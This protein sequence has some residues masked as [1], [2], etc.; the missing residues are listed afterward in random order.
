[1]KVLVINCGSSSVKYQLMDSETGS[2]LAKGM[3]ERIGFDDAVFTSVQRDP[4][5]LH[6]KAGAT[7]KDP[8]QVKTLPVKNHEIAMK[9]ILAGLVGERGVLGSLAEIGAVGHRFVNGG[10]EFIESVV[11]TD[12]VL[13]KLRRILDIAPLHNPANMLGIEACLTEM[14]DTPQ[15]IVFDTGF[16]ARVPAKAYMYALPYRYYEEYG[17]RRYGFHGTSHSYVSHRAAE[18]VG[19][20]V[21]DLRII[22]CHLGNGCSIDAVKDGWAVDTSMG[23]TPLEGLMMGTRTGDIDCAV[24]LSIMK[25]EGVTPEEMDAI[26]N[27]KSGLLGVTGIS[28]DMREIEGAARA[29]NE[30]AVLAIDMYCYRIRKYIAAYTGVL[31]GLDALVYTAGVGEHSSLVREKSCEGLEF[32]GIKIDPERNA[33]ATGGEAEIGICG[34]PVRILVVPTNE[35]LV[36]AREAERLGK[37]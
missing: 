10:R 18:L 32:L 6:A 17:I 13:G 24:P 26:L 25:R 37:R 31:S 2:V 5:L 20:P 35:E 21:R 27:R 23:Y 4:R 12:M 11:A 9:H 16:H 33:R 29:G 15:V 8:G 34:A 1:M 19:K 30:L 36:I 7:D 3:V 22:T 28:S 14:P